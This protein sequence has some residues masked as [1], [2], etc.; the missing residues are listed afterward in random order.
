[1]MPEDDA[2]DGVRIGVLGVEPFL[3]AK[4]ANLRPDAELLTL[5]ANDVTTLR[6]ASLDVVIVSSDHPGIEETV[7]ESGAIPVIVLSQPDELVA[8][9]AIGVDRPVSSP[10]LQQAIDQALGVGTLRRLARSLVVEQDDHDAM[11]RYAFVAR[12]GATLISLGWVGIHLDVMPLWTLILLA[13]YAVVRSLWWRLTLPGLVVDVAVVAP[14]AF[15]GIVAFESTPMVAVILPTII[16]MQVG[17]Q[18]KLWRGI[19]V[20]LGSFAIGEGLLWAS[21]DFGNPDIASLTASPAALALLSIMTGA[22]IERVV[23]TG[24]PRRRQDLERFRTVLYDLSERQAV[25]ALSLD[26]GTAAEEV[27]ARVLRQTGADAAVILVGEPGSS[28]KIAASHGLTKPPPP[29]LAWSPTTFHAEPGNAMLVAVSGVEV[30]TAGVEPAASAARPAPRPS[31][32]TPAEQVRSVASKLQGCLPEGRCISLPAVIDDDLLGGIVLVEP[33][34]QLGSA[35]LEEVAVEAALAFDSVR[36]FNRLRAF[37]LDQERARIGR[38]LHD[39]VMQTLSHVGMQ[40]DL[41]V[42]DDD[43]VATAESLRDLRGH[44]LATIAEMRAV[45]NDLR[46]VRLDRGLQAALETMAVTVSPAGG[47]LITVDCDPVVGLDPDVEE[48]LLRITQEAVSNAV[49]HSKASRISVSLRHD[50]ELVILQ[51]EDDGVGF[52]ASMIKQRGRD[53]T[54]GVGMTSIRQRV[55]AIGA[56]LDVDPGPGAIITVTHRPQRH[57]GHLGRATR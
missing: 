33:H 11:E 49:R 56:G 15:T 53:D 9:D 29:R 39:G 47:P 48:Q 19:G 26:V 46:S 12:I 27:L 37:T 40:L 18:L 52:T 42:R 17:Y 28:L 54:G 22:M 4:V 43:V 36:L 21:G 35:D 14:I 50:D 44:V 30:D 41:A 24:V 25:V 6:D 34:S 8:E 20:L 1:M 23:R 16:W 3:V 7:R 5:H 31:T 38:S 13:V 10:R 2:H 51:I 57:L 55:D 32:P 45:V